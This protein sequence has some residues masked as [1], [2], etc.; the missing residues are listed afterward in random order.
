MAGE[1]R[2]EDVVHALEKGKLPPFYLFYGPNEFIL[3]RLLAKIKDNYIPENARDFN[4]EICYGGESIPSDVIYCRIIS[5]GSPLTTSLFKPE[6][7]LKY[8][9]MNSCV[10]FS[11]PLIKD[12]AKLS[13]SGEAR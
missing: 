8:S 3:E 9:A 1:L 6:Y 11:A 13:T 12:C 10:F 5:A 2:P 7:P 4:M